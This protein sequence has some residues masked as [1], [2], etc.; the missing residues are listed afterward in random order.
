MQLCVNGRKRRTAWLGSKATGMNAARKTA[1]LA[2][3]LALGSGQ[4]SA[5]VDTRPLQLD[6]TAPALRPFPATSSPRTGNTVAPV[7][8]RGPAF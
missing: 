3:L 4:A 5:T 8:E 2:V 1:S 6:L 7:P